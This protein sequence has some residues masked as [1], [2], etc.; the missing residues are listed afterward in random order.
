MRDDIDTRT[1][2]ELVED[3][4]EGDVV[5][6]RVIIERYHDA[7][8]GFLT[9]LTG[10]R[11]LAE[12]VFQDT[13]LQ[14]HQSLETFDS[15]RRFKPWLFTIAANKGRD[16]LRK[17]QRRPTVSLSATMDDS[18]EG[19]SFVDLM[20]DDDPDI[21]RNLSDEDRSALVQK[22]V[23]RL[24]PRLREVLLLAY[25]QRMSYAQIAEV[26][27]IPLGTV[28]SRLHAAVSG[29]AKRWDEVVEEQRASEARAQAQWREQA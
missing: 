12:D 13:F 14:L 4:L 19:R 1:D 24:S 28:K 7:L 25:F 3:Y 2:E 8:M 5:A 27:Q 11:Q 15:S 16:A 10:Q 26:C 21:T 22:A 23:D 29:F 18:G 17:I 20:G 6:F 9:R